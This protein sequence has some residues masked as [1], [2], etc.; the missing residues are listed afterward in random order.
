MKSNS[1]R[2]K[3]LWG[4]WIGYIS[5][6]EKVV[7]SCSDKAVLPEA[8]YRTCRWKLGVVPLS[9]SKCLDGQKQ[10]WFPFLEMNN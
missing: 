5:K 10:H 8:A 2:S 7:P 9:Q 4:S 3:F 6:F 1:I